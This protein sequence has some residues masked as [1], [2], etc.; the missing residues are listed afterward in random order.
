MATA[1]LAELVNRPFG[2]PGVYLE[3]KFERRAL[4]F[5]LGDLSAMPPRKLLRVRDVFVS[6]THLDHFCGF[7]HLLRVCLGRHTGMNLF[8]PPEF[9]AQL[10]HR[11]AAYTW[12]LVDNYATEFV[13]FA[14]E[15][16]VTGRVQRARFSSRTRFKCQPMP[17]C[18]AEEGIVLEAPQFRVRAVALD[19]HDILSMAYAFEERMHINVLSGALKQLGMP[20]GPWLTHL[21]QQV[22]AQAADDTPIGIHWR[23]GASTEDRVLPLGELKQ[24]V[25]QFSAGQKVCYVTDIADT[26]SN[27][28]RLLEL[29]RDAELLFIEAVFLQADRQLA[30]RKSHLTAQAAGEIA[31]AAHVRAAVPFHFSARYLGREQALR[32]EF[33]RAWLASP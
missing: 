16:D 19:H 13:L 6:H 10:E 28:R 12:N 4:L 3:L 25:L 33:T 29:L 32:E 21:K 22:R 8:G 24:R 11:L 27:R 23:R 2:D 1:F 18:R 30:A 14:H 9:I 20:S 7:D 5:D 26:D 15:V 31:C 17:E